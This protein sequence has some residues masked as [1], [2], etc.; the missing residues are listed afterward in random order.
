VTTAVQVVRRFEILVGGSDFVGDVA[1]SVKEA[2]P[3]EMKS[4]VNAVQRPPLVEVRLEG[5]ARVVSDVMARI[6]AVHGPRIRHDVLKARGE[7]TRAVTVGQNGSVHPDLNAR[8]RIGADAVAPE[9]KSVPVTVA[10]VDS[11]LMVGHPA[12]TDHLWTGGG[13]IHGKQF[14]EGKSDG[15]IS[16]QDG[17]GTLLA[18]TILSA[19]AD[20]PVKLMTAKFF[21]AANPARPDNA[22]AALEFAVNNKA[23]IILLAWD[24]GLGSVRLQD[25]FREAGTHALVVIAAGN[26][27]SDNDWHDGQSSARAPVRYAKDFPSSTIT[28][29]ATDESDEKAWF[30]NYG[31]KTVDLAAPGA[32]IVST[33]RALSKAPTD[34]P[35]RYRAHSGTSPAAAYVAGAAALLMSRYPSLTVREI[36]DCLVDSVDKLPGLKCASGGRLCIPA[37]LERAAKLAKGKP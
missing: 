27:G 8:E 20:A 9:I 16:D 1:R 34:E 32:G 28:V 12:L 10:I 18:G 24:V 14:I 29:M 15:D 11:G 6:E 26:Y 3:P 5:A 4:E 36:K 7:R 22:A 31:P 21:D 37:A 2:V 19:A 33:R 17:H 35:K 30:S 13:G 25:A 23:K